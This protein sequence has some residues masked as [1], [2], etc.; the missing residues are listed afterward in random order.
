MTKRFLVILAAGAIFTGAG[1][2]AAGN[3][4]S[5]AQSDFYAP[6]EHQ[7]YMWCPASEDYMAT[8][9]GRNAEDAQLRLYDA[10]KAAGRAGCWPVWQGRLRT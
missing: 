5:S 2:A 3:F 9:T 7:F 8:E 6:G 1:V 10:S 4:T